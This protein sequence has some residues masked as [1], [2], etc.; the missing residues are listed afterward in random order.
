MEDE[1]FSA[2]RAKILGIQLNLPRAKIDTLMSNNDDDA[3]A[4]LN[5]VIDSWLEQTEPSW[6]EL[7][8]ALE[9]SYCKRIANDGVFQI[10]NS[11]HINFRGGSR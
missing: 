3:N 8:L 2:A 1:G 10:K 5:Y 11:Y 6:E 7:A 9:K 4:L